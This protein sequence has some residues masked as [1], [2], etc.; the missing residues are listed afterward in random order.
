M[1]TAIVIP[2][3]FIYF[4]WL[5]RKEIRE[6]HEKWL[7]LEHVPEE[8]V[9]TGKILELTEARERFYYHRFNHVLNIKVQTDDKILTVKKITPIREGATFPEIT[10]GE[11]VRFYGNWKEGYFQVGRIEGKN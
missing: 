5:T 10:P 8:A 3:I 4:Y 9:I 2:I 1:V 11:H 7:Q 6:N